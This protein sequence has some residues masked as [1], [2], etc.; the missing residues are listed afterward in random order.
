MKSPPPKDIPVFELDSTTM[1]LAAMVAETFPL[2][3]CSSTINPKPCPTLNL[4][5]RESQGNY[6]RRIPILLSGPYNMLGGL[7]DIRFHNLN[8]VSTNNR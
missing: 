2:G 5:A 6:E 3:K 7:S 1:L 8:E 4:G